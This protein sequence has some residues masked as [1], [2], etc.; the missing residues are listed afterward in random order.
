[1]SAHVDAVTRM[2]TAADWTC[3]FISRGQP[4]IFQKGPRYCEVGQTQTHFWRKVK[5]DECDHVFV[6]TDSPDQI[7]RHVEAA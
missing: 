2:L 4:P 7:K 1:M 6:D 5:G 3:I